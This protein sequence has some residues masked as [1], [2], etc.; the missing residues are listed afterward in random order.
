MSPRVRG[1]S[2]TLAWFEIH[3]S[4]AFLFGQ[5][6]RMILSSVLAAVPSLVPFLEQPKACVR[7]SMV[8]GSPKQTL[9]VKR[10]WATPP[11]DRRKKQVA[12]PGRGGSN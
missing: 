2:L 8:P 7:A 6:S 1:P 3:D 4:V 10:P 5:V 11:L 9:T 12:T